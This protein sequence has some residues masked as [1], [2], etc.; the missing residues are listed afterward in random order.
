[1]QCEYSGCD[2]LKSLSYRNFITGFSVIWFLWLFFQGENIQLGLFSYFYK[3]FVASYFLRAKLTFWWNE[4]WVNISSVRTW[5]QRLAVILRG[6]INTPVSPRWIPYIR[7]RNPPFSHDVIRRSLALTGAVWRH[8]PAVLPGAGR[9]MARL[10]SPSEPALPAGTQPA[11]A[12]EL[13]NESTRF[14]SWVRCILCNDFVQCSLAWR[15]SELFSKAEA[16]P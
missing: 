12:S 2:N 1:M 16:K 8:T 10:P 9:Q 7:F 13:R 4:R 15:S 5:G 11:R 3:S 6:C 14:L